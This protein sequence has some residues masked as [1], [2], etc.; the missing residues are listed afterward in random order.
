[1]V[2]G[3]QN[4]TNP[5]LSLKWFVTNFILLPFYVVTLVVI[6][7]LPCL[8]NTSIL[9]LSSQLHVGTRKYGFID[10]VM[11]YRKL[12]KQSLWC[13]IGNAIKGHDVR[14]FVAKELAENPIFHRIQKTEKS[15]GKLCSLHLEHWQGL[16]VA[17]LENPI[18][19][20]VLCMWPARRKGMQR[21]LQGQFCLIALLNL[22]IFTPNPCPLEAMDGIAF[23]TKEDGKL[24]NW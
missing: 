1:M 3:R 15:P 11:S 24:G 9:K 4:D 5:N 13:L 8:T 6:G 22:L 17:W 18:I 23:C 7:I 16:D 2:P 14:R 10:V 20:E 19:G 21:D 12:I